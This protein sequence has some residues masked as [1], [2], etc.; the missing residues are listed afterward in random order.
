MALS[1]LEDVRINKNGPY[2]EYIAFK[3]EETL[4]QVCARWP[5]TADELGG[6]VQYVL[7]YRRSD[8]GTWTCFV[9]LRSEPDDTLEARRLALCESLH[10]SAHSV[11]PNVTVDCTAVG[12][13]VP[14]WP[15]HNTGTYWTLGKLQQHVRTALI[16]TQHP[17][18]SASPPP[19]AEPL[20][21]VPLAAVPLAAAPLA[22]DDHTR[23]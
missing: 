5:G 3:P 23:S 7:E 21:A 22:E 20:V 2:Y 8:V 10:D 6:T 15:S 4:I 1:Y 11:G 19:E 14:R 18:P 17:H 16:R 13:Y 9:N 12:D